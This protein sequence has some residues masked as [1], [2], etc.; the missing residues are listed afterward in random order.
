MRFQKLW[1]SILLVFFIVFG[2]DRAWS[3]DAKQQQ[4]AD[5]PEAMME[6]YL[7]I[8][9]PGPAHKELE[10]RAGKWEHVT[11]MWFDPSKPPTESKGTTEYRLILG[12]RYLLQEFSGEFLGKPFNGVGF[13][14]YDNFKKQYITVWIDSIG[15]SVFT[16]LGSPDASGNVITYIGEMDEPVT[17]EKNKKIRSVERIV[18]N[19]RHIFEMYDNIPGV[20]EVKTMEIT[21]TRKK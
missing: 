19:D 2:A 5:S 8:G 17:G 12:G 1:C 10:K 9:Q 7:K 3:Q 13:I 6:Q 4:P 21:Y 11:K 15:T 14:G 16:S 18:D 20:G